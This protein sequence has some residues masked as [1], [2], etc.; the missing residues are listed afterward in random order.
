MHSQGTR[1]YQPAQ[2]FFLTILPSF[3]ALLAATHPL[4]Q[5][6]P[7]A[8]ACAQSP[9]CLW[10]VMSLRGLEEGPGQAGPG[11]AGEFVVVEGFLGAEGA[12]GSRLCRFPR[13]FAGVNIFKQNFSLSC[14]PRLTVS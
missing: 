5:A 6:F 14:S 2:G 3:D 7:R 12:L 13:R 4:E 11:E 1:G 8:A 10:G 9:F